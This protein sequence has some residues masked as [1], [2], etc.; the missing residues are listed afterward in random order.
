MSV[1]CSFLDQSFARQVCA[2]FNIATYLF[3]NLESRVHRERTA[4]PD[5]RSDLERVVEDAISSSITPV[6]MA[7]QTVVAITRG[8]SWKCVVG[9]RRRIFQMARSAFRVVSHISANYREYPSVHRNTRHTGHYSI[10]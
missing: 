9:H 2:V 7:T 10:R 6:G 3:V 5:P 8:R 4:V 1:A